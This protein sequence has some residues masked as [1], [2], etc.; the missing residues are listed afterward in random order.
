M[1][2]FYTP[3]QPQNI[4]RIVMMIM[5]GYLLHKDLEHKDL[6]KIIKKIIKN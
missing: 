4:S 2:F 3:K 1:S 6:E 5:T